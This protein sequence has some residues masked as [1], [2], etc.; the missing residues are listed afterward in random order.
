MRLFYFFCFLF[1]LLS[2]KKVELN[3]ISKSSWSPKIALPLAYGSF[4]ISDILEQADSVDKYLQTKPSLQLV[5][6]ESV[7]GFSLEEALKIPNLDAIPSTTLID[8]NQSNSL[9][10]AINENSQTGFISFLDILPIINPNG[11]PLIQEVPLTNPTKPGFIDTTTIDEI[12]FSEGQI[13]I[14]IVTKIQHKIEVVYEISEMTNSGK[15]L[16][17]SII[18]DKS[19]PSDSKASVIEL[20]NV[21]ANLKSKKLTFTIKKILLTFNNYTVTQN[22]KIDIAVSMNNIKFE[23]I[24]GYFGKLGVPPINQTLKLDQLTSLK[25]KGEFG[26]TNPSLKLFIKNSFGIPVNINFNKFQIKQSGQPIDITMS[27]TFDIKQPV[28]ASAEPALDSIVFNK[29]TATNFDQLLSSKNESIV[30]GADIKINK[31]GPDP[32][33]RNFISSKSSIALDAEVRVPLTGYAKKFKFED[34]SDVSLPFDILNSLSLIMLYKNSL[35]VEVSGSIRFLDKQGNLIKDNQNNVI[36]LLSN[37][38]NIIFKC[39]K[40]TKIDNNGA[41]YLDENDIKNMVE[42]KLEIKI[43]SNQVPYLLNATKVIFKGEFSTFQ[44][45]NSSSSLNKDTP[46]TLYDYYGL[47]IKL[48]GDAKGKLPSNLK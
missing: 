7:K 11:S 41:Y 38:S 19:R 29:T 24:Y 37:S 5:V 8:L 9:I 3:T 36:D 4:A 6:K 22:D 20:N 14:D 46:I 18:C 45:P 2:C 39:P 1:F 33:N 21:K 25:E 12:N 43:T 32:I 48:L 44:L 13:K 28:N 10:S 35:P 16:S 40:L 17:G 26:L 42:E 31:N 47:S 34:T 27:K 23:S 30:F 15:I